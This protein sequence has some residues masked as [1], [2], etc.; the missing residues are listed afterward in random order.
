MSERNDNSRPDILG[1]VPQSGVNRN[2]GWAGPAE[3]KVNKPQP[4]MR[5]AARGGGGVVTRTERI[6]S[7]EGSQR[8]VLVLVLVGYRRRQ[9]REKRTR[10]RS[11]RAL[12]SL[13][14]SSSSSSA[15]SRVWT[16][17]RLTSAGL[18]CAGPSFGD[19]SPGK[20]TPSRARGQVA[21]LPLI[22]SPTILR[23]GGPIK[24]H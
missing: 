1:R 15:W 9:N 20:G 11:E 10:E 18:G 14:S 7:E 17:P 3:S 5:W 21:C 4:Q 6:K 16:P 13:L 2:D 24:D 8:E 19:W 12:L 22:C 23:A